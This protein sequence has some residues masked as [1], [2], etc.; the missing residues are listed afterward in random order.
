[1]DQWG[2]TLVFLP[3]FPSSLLK[4]IVWTICH[5]ACN[6]S[7]SEARDAHTRDTF[8]WTNDKVEPIL[9]VLQG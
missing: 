9:K 3:Y 7:P 6:T 1:M 4:A 2:K 8:Y 5:P